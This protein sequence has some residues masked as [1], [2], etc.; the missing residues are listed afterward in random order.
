MYSSDTRIEAAALTA[1]ESL[2]RT[3]YPNPKDTPSGLAQ[4]V[5]KQS[6]EILQEPEKTQ[7]VSITKALAALI[8]ASRKYSLVTKSLWI[9]GAQRLHVHSPFLRPYLNYSGN[10]TGLFYHHIELPS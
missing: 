10:S 5:I 3:L 2:M 7:G 6:L 1:L 4:D 8:R 9:D